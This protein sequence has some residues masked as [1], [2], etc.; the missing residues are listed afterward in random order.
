MTHGKSYTESVEYFLKLLNEYEGKVDQLDRLD[1]ANIMLNIL[2]MIFTSVRGWAGWYF[3]VKFASEYLS[4]DDMVRDV[5]KMIEIAK[6]LLTYDL[7]RTKE[8]LKKYEEKHGKQESER[9]V[10]YSI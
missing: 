7:E 4:R 8:W 10:P 3:S 1:L 5:K 2:S 6:Q 9:R